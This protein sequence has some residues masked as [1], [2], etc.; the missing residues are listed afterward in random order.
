MA[1]DATLAANIRAALGAY[2]AALTNQ[3]TA[4]AALDAQRANVQSA[5]QVVRDAFAA[6]SVTTVRLNA[7]L[8]TVGEVI[9][10]MPD[11]DSV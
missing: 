10:Q 2:K 1:I 6:A 4:K 8:I 7:T 11:F 9:T 3:A 5:E